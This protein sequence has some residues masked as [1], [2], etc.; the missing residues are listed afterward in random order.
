VDKRTQAERMQYELLRTDDYTI[1]AQD[2]QRLQL[3]EDLRR[4]KLL[5]VQS[6]R[7]LESQEAVD[8]GWARPIVWKYHEG[9]LG[10]LDVAAAIG[11]LLDSSI[12]RGEGN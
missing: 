11:G 2:G 5:D 8:E 12:C 4:E 7:V 6:Q 10:L 3:I 1:E 9:L